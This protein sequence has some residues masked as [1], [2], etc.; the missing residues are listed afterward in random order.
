MTEVRG[1]KGARAKHPTA[2]N[3]SGLT[4]R[5][6]NEVVDLDVLEYCRV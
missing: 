5:V 3:H 1:G 4:G 2:P 6:G